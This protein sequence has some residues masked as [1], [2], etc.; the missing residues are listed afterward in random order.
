VYREWA[1]AC[2]RFNLQEN[3]V[4][5]PGK[6]ARNSSG[7]VENLDAL[8]NNMLTMAFVQADAAWNL[9]QKDANVQNLR[10]LAVLYP[11]QV[12]L[13][14]LNAPV[15]VKKPTLGFGGETKNLTTA[16]DLKGLTVA[17]WGGSAV[18]ASIIRDYMFSGGL[19]VLEVNT[20]DE[21]LAAVTQGRAHVIIAV[22]GAPMKWVS[23]LGPEWKLLA[24]PKA[25]REKVGTTYAD[26]RL[27]YPKMGANGVESGETTSMLVAQN[28]GPR[29]GRAITEAYD[30]MMANREDLRDQIGTHPAWKKID[31]DRKS[32]IL[33][34]FN[35]V[36]DGAPASVVVPRKK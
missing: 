23:A 9:L 16:A 7:T 4:T 13:L 34:G 2:S 28:Y 18:T 19:N 17:A 10:A 35:F 29:M 24:F 26:A 12:H 14:T 22:G 21:A 25:L 15:V 36:R 8:L 32:N 3:K 1:H 27:S 6:P 5:L 33:A 30:C 11:E 20:K 31:P